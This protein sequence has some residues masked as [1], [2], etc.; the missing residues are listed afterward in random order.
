MKEHLKYARVSRW[1]KEK[2]QDSKPSAR[3]SSF[4]I[5]RVVGAGQP[6]ES[7]VQV[8][9]RREF[10]R[11]PACL[12]HLSRSNP[13]IFPHPRQESRRWRLQFEGEG[14]WRFHR[15]SSREQGEDSVS[16]VEGGKSEE[17]AKRHTGPVAS[18]CSQRGRPRLHGFGD[19]WQLGA[20][21]GHGSPAPAS[22]IRR[23]FRGRPPLR[24][25][26]DRHQHHTACDQQC[27]NPTPAPHA[28]VQKYARGDRVGH[29]GKRG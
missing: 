8:T 23:A 20:F 19:W 6:I 27:R 9:V 16:P 5:C 28:F 18:L 15:T 14:V 11:E 2:T 3:D 21:G 13:R 24:E 29:K 26:S 25:I 22:L 17:R 10:K 4:R 12:L 7:V 1:C